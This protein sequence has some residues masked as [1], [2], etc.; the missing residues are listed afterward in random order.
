MKNTIRTKVLASVLATVCAVS[1]MSTVA[2]VSVSAASISRSSFV[3]QSINNLVDIQ[4]TYDNEFTISID[5]EDWTYYTDSMNVKVSCDYN[6]NYD[7]CTFKI[8]ALKQGD[9]N[10]VLKTQFSDGRW[11]NTPIAVHVFNDLTMSVFQTSMA[12]ITEKSYIQPGEGPDADLIK[13]AVIGKWEYNVGSKYNAFEL[14]ENNKAAYIF[15]DGSIAQ[16]KW[17]IENGQIYLRIAGGC[18]VFEIRNGRL[19]DA[20]QGIEYLKVNPAYGHRQITRS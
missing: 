11:S 17:Q 13:P 7:I 3:S 18:E 16:A 20:F 4:R 10:V 5:G 1:V 14:Y 6:Y 8:T 2:A 15:A 19:Y 9:A 12:Y